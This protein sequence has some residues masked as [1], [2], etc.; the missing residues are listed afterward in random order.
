MS[1][2]FTHSLVG[3]SL[4]LLAPKQVSGT[5][6]ILAA[7][8]LAILPDA[9]VL[10]FRMG[11]PYEHMYGHRGFTHSILFSCVAAFTASLLF[12]KPVGFANRNWFAV[13]VI[14]F[15]TALNMRCYH[16]GRLIKSECLS[17]NNSQSCATSQ[18]SSR[19]F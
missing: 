13:F 14:L 10:A 15:L 4:A 2:V 11:I 16:V 8:V 17:N 18:R 6:I 9:D 7:I 12:F 1:T 3:A 19:L 5:S